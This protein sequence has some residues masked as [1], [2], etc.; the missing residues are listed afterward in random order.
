MW[1]NRYLWPIYTT[2]DYGLECLGH[3]FKFS[4]IKSL[5][6][7]QKTGTLVNLQENYIIEILHQVLGNI[8]ITFNIR[9][10]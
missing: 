8:Y 9:D 4:N 1:L 5:C 3:E 7:K 6:N 2:Y 10:N